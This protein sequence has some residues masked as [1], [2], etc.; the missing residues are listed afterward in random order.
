MP[1]VLQA[2]PIDSPTPST[3]PLMANKKK[4]FQ[5]LAYSSDIWSNFGQVQLSF[6]QIIVY[7]YNLAKG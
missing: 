1:R 5:K 2:L 3:H 4:L 7:N 6:G